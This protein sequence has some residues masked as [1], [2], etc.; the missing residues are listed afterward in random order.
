LTHE[1]STTI[2]PLLAIIHKFSSPSSSSQMA[3]EFA[4]NFLEAIEK[5]LEHLN[6]KA[7]EQR[8]LDAFHGSICNLCYLFAANMVD[9]GNAEF[10]VMNALLRQNYPHLMKYHSQDQREYLKLLGTSRE[11]LQDFGL[12]KGRYYQFD[13][14]EGK[15]ADVDKEALWQFQKINEIAGSLTGNIDKS[16]GCVRS[17]IAEELSQEV[18]CDQGDDNEG[19]QRPNANQA[20]PSGKYSLLLY[21]ID[22]GCH[23]Q[24]YQSSKNQIDGE[25]SLLQQ[26]EAKKDEFIGKMIRLAAETNSISVLRELIKNDLKSRPPPRQLRTVDV[27]DFKVESSNHNKI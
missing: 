18:W 20:Y 4:E 9:S 15:M 8:G 27:K 26:Q 17:A 24:A 3:Q 6:D 12:V 10:Q 13:L 23:V 22:Q 14:D 1:S 2:L 19:P 11:L 16:D 25:A 5:L 21:M 7:G